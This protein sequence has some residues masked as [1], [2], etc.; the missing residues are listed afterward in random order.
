VDRLNAALSGRYRIERPLGEGGMA[1]VYLADD[2]RHERKVAL[3]ILKPE[4]AAMLGAERFLAEIKTTA[5]LQHPHILP[6]YDS[7]EVDGFLFFVMPFME[8]ESL[9]DRLDREH[10]LPVDEAVRV[11]TNVAEALDYAHARGVIH[12]DIKPANI[13]LHAGKPLVADFGIALAART[14]GGQRLTETGLSLGTPFY[15][16]P[17]QAAGDQVV[18][19]STDLYALGCVLYEML[20][21]EPPHVGSTAQAVLAKILTGAVPALSERRR[22]VPPNVEG[23][24]RKALE[25]LPADRFVSAGDL[26]RALAD[27]SFRYWGV[28][29][30]GAAGGRAWGVSSAGWRAVALTATVVAGVSAAFAITRGLRP[31]AGESEPRPTRVTLV[32]TRP[33]A[34]QPLVSP[35]AISPDGRQVVFL[36]AEAGRLSLYRRSLDQPDVSAISGNAPLA[37]TDAPSVTFSPDGRSVAF[38]A[39]DGLVRRVSI[40]GGAPATVAHTGTVPLGLSWSEQYGIVM[41]M[42]S[43]SAQA[44]LTRAVPGDTTVLKVVEPDG[45][46]MQ[47]D[48][49]VLPGGDYAIYTHWDERGSGRPVGEGGTAGA[50]LAGEGPRSLTLG[51]VGLGDGSV[52]LHELDPTPSGAE[53]LVG[54]AEGVLLYWDLTRTLMAVAWDERGRRPVGRA[55][56]VP[57]VPAGAA[58][59][60]LAEDGTLAMVVGSDEAELVIVNDRGDLLTPVSDDPFYMAVPRFSRDGARLAVAGVR[61]GQADV[62]IYD[63]GGG[64][65]SLL[66]MDVPVRMV[67]WTPDGRDVLGSL[68]FDRRDRGGQIW[69]RPADA[70]DRSRPR[71]ELAGT[72][73]WAVE[74]A[75]DGRSLALLVSTSSDPNT[76]AYDIVIRSLVGDTLPVPFAAGDANEVAPR[77]S[78]DG[79]WLAYASNE[80]G[81]YEV[82]ARPFPGPGGRV[83]LSDAGGGQPVWSADGRRLFYRGESGLVVARL[84]R[85][86]ADRLR[87]LSR[88]RLFDDALIGGPGS[89][90]AT[91]DVHPD[92]DRLA[93]ARGRGAGTE[94]VLWLDWLDDVKALLDG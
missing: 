91:Y 59:A 76:P 23:A 6:L 5:N 24:V 43:F 32:D 53:A 72:E 67:A 68:G 79:R 8:G 29:D 84:E 17:E 49:K 51:V 54:V 75:P 69:S 20:A 46:F 36:G 64:P 66:A 80:S 34:P 50:A 81:R 28:A 71:W 65:L 93:V 26:Q 90:V 21:G 33:G 44:A 74:P 63:V 42:F 77:F 25:R 22:T 39:T 78:P 83:Q 73:V 56:A 86:G 70:S 85:D 61:P 13:L 2:L 11:A 14:A 62:W 10:Q 88:E 48:P 12:R 92:G 47:H 37:G 35:V 57:D 27:P 52:E 3:K 1:T 31:S 9:Q 60:S 18:R 41:G 7:G 55:V 94:I 38:A 16:S 82:Y 15:M 4:L 58:F 89:T 30:A 45:T 40:E 87:V 19:P